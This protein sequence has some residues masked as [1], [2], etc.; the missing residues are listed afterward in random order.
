MDRLG[1]PARGFTNPA[2]RTA[3]AELRELWDHRELLFYI[4]WRDIKVRYKQAVLGVA[5]IVIQPIVS[6]AI[7]SLLFGRLLKVPSGNVPYPVFATAALLPW[8]Y[9]AG[10]LTRAS[11]SLVSSAGLYTKIYFPRLVIP[12]S[13]ILGGLVD[14]AI[15][16]AVLIGL[17]LIYGVSP[18][19]LVLTL[20]AFIL[21]ASMA[22][23]AF[24]L[25][26]SALNVRYR[27]V[28]HLIPFLV[29]VWMYATPVVYGTDLIPQRWRFLLGL[30]PM[31]TVTEGFRWALVGGP[32]PG[33]TTSPIVVG[34][35]LMLVCVVLLGGL[36]YFRHTE[37][38]FADVV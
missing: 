33:S 28:G 7:F 11:G 12:I 26:L 3:R 23:L 1:V 34:G 31:T 32:P 14:L 20:P 38:T 25:W 22:A 6:I 8:N 37:R 27:D 30:N 5:W 13:A 36:A 10:A 24:S 15:S 18:S 9:F 4:A 16:F 19:L 17:M 21:L 29:Q 2:R 35:S